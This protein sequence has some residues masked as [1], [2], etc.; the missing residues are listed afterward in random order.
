MSGTC[1]RIDSVERPVVTL[2]RFCIF[3]FPIHA[4]QV[5]GANPDVLVPFSRIR[6]NARHMFYEPTTLAST[7][8]VLAT[9]LDRE[10]GIAPGPIFAE[11]DLELPPFDSPQLRYPLE[12]MRRLWA[13]AVAATGD[14]QVGLKTGWYVKP[15]HLY[16]FGYSFMASSNLLGAFRRLERYYR[17]MST[18]SVEVRIQE[19]K[20]GYALSAAFPDESREPPKEGIDSGM[21]ALLALCDA[22]AERPIRPVRI[23]LT[24]PPTV[25]PDGYRAAL[26]A[27]ID[28]GADLGKFVFDRETLEAPLPHGTPDVAR[29]TDRIADAYLDLLDP[30]KLAS[31]VRR[32]L[33]EMLPSGNVDQERISRRLN[34]ST[35]TL[36]RQLQAEGLSYREVLES[37]RRGLAETYLEDGRHSHAQIAYLLGFSEQ[38]NFSRAFRRWTSMSPREF[39]TARRRQSNKPED[40]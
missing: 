30:G 18:A 37:T 14:E 9:A 22:V 31:Q 36:Q 7:T 17:V 5:I 8:A 15:A 3:W 39:Q 29:A 34:R 16:A 35:S 12:K 38:S 21:T 24:C 20:D 28:F 2:C 33:I 23:E 6:F 25:H 40:D 4:R 11:A 13:A 26:G 27:P 1:H 19:A 10:Y 32:L